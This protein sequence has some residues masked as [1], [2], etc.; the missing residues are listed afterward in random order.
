MLRC[1]QFIMR[2]LDLCD[3]TLRKNWKK[4]PHQFIILV[5]GTLQLLSSF[6]VQGYAA[7]PGGPSSLRVGSRGRI[8]WSSDGTQSATHAKIDGR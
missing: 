6:D 7:T 3:K 1:V 4:F 8:Q 5:N 2:A